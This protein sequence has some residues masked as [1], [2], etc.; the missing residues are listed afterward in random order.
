M[1]TNGKLF[2]LREVEYLMARRYEVTR[3]FGPMSVG[4]VGSIVD[5]RQ[6]GVAGGHAQRSM[7][8]ERDRLRGCT[9]RPRS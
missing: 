2:T 1:K 7:Y 3:R 4:E 9:R 5:V 6:Q 8:Q